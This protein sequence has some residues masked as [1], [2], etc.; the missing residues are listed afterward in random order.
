MIILRFDLY[1]KRSSSVI[2]TRCPSK[3]HRYS[4][5]SWWPVKLG[6]L[7]Q[8]WQMFAPCR[9]KVELLS[10]PGVVKTSMA[11][12][13]TCSNHMAALNCMQLLMDPRNQ[14]ASW[15]SPEQWD[16]PAKPTYSALPRRPGGS[17]S[18][19]RPLGTLLS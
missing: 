17:Y 13:A 5:A 7:L 4:F 15:E 1:Q 9:S 18:V 3:L 19:V 6:W 14:S 8:V 2:H 11:L 10:K 12:D 16:T